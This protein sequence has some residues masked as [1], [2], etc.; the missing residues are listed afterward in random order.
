M[1][2]ELVTIY[3]SDNEIEAQLYQ[4]LLEEAGIPAMLQTL[5]D[6]W[7]QR[8]EIVGQPRARFRLLVH[9]ENAGQAG[10]LVEAFR[11]QAEAGE[12]EQEEE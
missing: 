5:P 10:E 11:A 8:G 2:D 12:L 9:A 4:A 1:S 6:V 7:G 3:T